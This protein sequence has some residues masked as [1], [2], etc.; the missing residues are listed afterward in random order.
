MPAKK[1][2]KEKSE[3]D[4]KSEIEQSAKLFDI[5]KPPGKTPAS[6][7]SRPLIVGH[8]PMIK[9]DPM[10]KEEKAES[11]EKEAEEDNKITVRT[12]STVI[13]P[14]ADRKDEDSEQE[15]PAAA[16]KTTDDNSAKD[17]NAES[18]TA[19]P[20]ENTQ[21]EEV[22][23]SAPESKSDQEEPVEDEP[24]ESEK[25]EDA[26]RNEETENNDNT[27]SKKGVVDSLAN[28]VSAKREEQKEKEA[29]AAVVAEA[30]KLIQSKQY[31]VPIG[32]VSRKRANNFLA[33]FVLIIVI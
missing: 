8:T 23:T 17:E 5:A 3:R 24:V 12:H 7:S 14:L 31:F 18:K 25:K 30:E 4:L 21:K 11:E 27:D 2:P 28:E 33:F 15:Q 6:A 16:E 22:E 10:V 13:K 19:E 29:Q 26:D 20:T 9:N 32:Q 1:S